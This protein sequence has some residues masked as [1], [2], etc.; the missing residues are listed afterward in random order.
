MYF[1]WSGNVQFSAVNIDII[2]LL[3]FAMTLCTK[4]R[5]TS[6]HIDLLHQFCIHTQSTCAHESR[7]ART[8][9]RAVQWSADQVCIFHCDVIITPQHTVQIGFHSVQCG[10]TGKYCKEIRIKWFNLRTKVFVVACIKI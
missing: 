9:V 10:Y 5:S 8:K 6:N 3:C 4:L 2:T 1:A 7:A